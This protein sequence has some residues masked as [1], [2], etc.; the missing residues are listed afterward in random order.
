MNKMCVEKVKKN[1]KK[2]AAKLHSSKHQKFVDEGF[3]NTLR[4]TNRPLEDRVLL[5]VRAKFST[6]KIL[7]AIIDNVSFFYNKSSTLPY[8]C[9]L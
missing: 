4:D 1:M 5:S 6:H 2:I 7:W 8:R 9:I 3:E